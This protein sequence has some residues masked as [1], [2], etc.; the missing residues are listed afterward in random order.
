MLKKVAV[1][2][3][4]MGMFI[5]ELS[6]SWMEHPFWKTKFVLTDPEDLKRLVDSSIKEVWID[7]DQGFDVSAE[8]AL[9]ADSATKVEKEVEQTLSE[10]ESSGELLSPH[11]SLEEEVDRAAKVC[12]KA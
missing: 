3:V 10:A 5:H 6:G 1:S 2:D 4:R 8:R 9:K 7:T 12:A 11:V